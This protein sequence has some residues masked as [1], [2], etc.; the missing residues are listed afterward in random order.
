MYISHKKTTITSLKTF[1]SS[2]KWQELFPNATAVQEP[3]NPTF[4]QTGAPTVQAKDAQFVPKKY[5]FNEVIAI[6]SFKG[7]R[8]QYKIDLHLKIK[9]N[10]KT[11]RPKK[12]SVLRTKGCVSK[13]F[14]KKQGLLSKSMPW[15][16]VEAFIPFKEN[17]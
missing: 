14:K 7:K 1:P 8:E 10:A 16:F 13:K 4:K 11:K 5:E 17:K 2:T 3:A 6:P 9:I 12:K 15:D